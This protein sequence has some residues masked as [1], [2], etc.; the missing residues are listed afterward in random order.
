[1]TIQVT[2]KT[3]EETDN[4]LPSTTARMLCRLIGEDWSTQS[5]GQTYEFDIKLTAHIEQTLDTDPWIKSWKE[6]EVSQADHYCSYCADCKSCF[7]PDEFGQNFD[8]PQCGRSLVES[9][10]AHVKEHHC[11]LEVPQ[12]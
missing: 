10:R 6:I 7:S 11:E 3:D 12:E 2:F 4:T 5:E 9:V 1:M 8:C